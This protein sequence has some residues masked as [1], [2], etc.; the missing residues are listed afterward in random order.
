MGTFSQFE[1][2]LKPT[3][4]HHHVISNPDKSFPGINQYSHLYKELAYTM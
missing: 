3:D 2:F 1:I 4:V